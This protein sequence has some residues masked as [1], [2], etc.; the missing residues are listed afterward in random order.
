MEYLKIAV[1]IH[2][3]TVKRNFVCL[4]ALMLSYQTGKFD[5]KVLLLILAAPMALLKL[6]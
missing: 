4:D 2:A 6:F 5:L 1:L 3:I